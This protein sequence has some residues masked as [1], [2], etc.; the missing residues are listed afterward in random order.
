[1]LG[2]KRPDRPRAFG[3]Y[4]F[5]LAAA[6]CWRCIFNLCMNCGPSS[7]VRSV[8]ELTA[9]RPTE[10]FAESSEFAILS[11]PL[12]SPSSASRHRFEVLL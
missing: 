12:H 10:K 5:R 1:M 2:V 4:E 3:A 6:E 11:G 7:S 9:V 8:V